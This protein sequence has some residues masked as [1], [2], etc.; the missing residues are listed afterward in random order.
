MADRLAELEARVKQLEEQKLTL[1]DL[2]MAALQRKLETD[3]QP[4]AEQF[5]LP[6][7]VTAEALS[8][9]LMKGVICTSTTR[10][11]SPHEGLLI[12]ETDINNVRVWDGA[13]WIAVAP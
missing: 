7:T 6:G 2:P 3:F 8:P 13:T 12:Y 1:R 9:E 5:L 10:P 4:D 11:A